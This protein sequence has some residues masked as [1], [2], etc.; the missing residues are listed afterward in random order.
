MSRPARVAHRAPQETE[1]EQALQ[2]M[3]SVKFDDQAEP[4]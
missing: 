3:K 4:R 1:L 2:A